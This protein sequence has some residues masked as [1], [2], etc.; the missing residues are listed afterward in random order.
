MGNIK[1]K[2]LCCDNDA[3]FWDMC[4][5]CFWEYTELIEVN[6][7]EEEKEKPDV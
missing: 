4:M 5:D 2:C 3:V 7:V 1:Q 6:A